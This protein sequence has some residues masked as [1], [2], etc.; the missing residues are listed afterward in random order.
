MKEIYAKVRMR[1]NIVEGCK[2]ARNF[3]NTPLKDIKMSLTNGE[4]LLSVDYLEL[5][6]LKLLKQ[7]L[8]ELIRLG[9]EVSVFREYREVDVDYLNNTIQSY[10]EIT[11]E[12]GV[13]NNLIVDNQ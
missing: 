1:D 4:K 6:E 13:R 5:D 12:R 10:E 7:L 2:I 11:Q 9:G 3:T 8:D